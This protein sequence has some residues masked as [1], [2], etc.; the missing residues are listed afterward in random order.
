MALR[1]QPCSVLSC[2]T[3]SK[4]PGIASAGPARLTV[5]L[6][7]SKESA[8]HWGTSRRDHYMSPRLVQ[9]QLDTMEIPEN[10]II[11]NSEKPTEE[12]VTEVL[13]QTALLQ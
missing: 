2:C 11:I 10:A 1:Q 9:S 8:M 5:W 7:I 12:A 13:S 3:K 4:L 6:D